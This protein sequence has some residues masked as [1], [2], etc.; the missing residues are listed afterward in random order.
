MAAHCEACDGRV[1]SYRAYAVW[2]RR[3]ARCAECG[4]AVRLRHFWTVVG[5]GA[6]L[7]VAALFLL[8][9]LPMPS[10][11]VGVIV[12]MSVA[13]LAL[14]YASYHLL[15]WEVDPSLEGE[16]GGGPPRPLPP[17]V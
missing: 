15:T 8:T 7:L 6:G 13:L 17:G 9:S 10:I 14:D 1:M 5:L 4:S 2:T 11:G 16:G 12:A 3:T